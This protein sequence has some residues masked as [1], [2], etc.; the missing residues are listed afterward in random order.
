MGCGGVEPRLGL[1][2]LGWWLAA[3]L[4]K[5]GGVEV[6]NLATRFHQGFMLMMEGLYPGK[7]YEITQLSLNVVK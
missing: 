5:V 6:G 1:L 2:R 7:W 3:I 4:A